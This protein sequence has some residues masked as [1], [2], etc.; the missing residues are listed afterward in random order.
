LTVLDVSGR[1]LAEAAARLGAAAE[2]VTWLEG[3]V[4]EARLPPS[5]YDV[6]HDRAVFHFLTEPDH[7]RRYVEQ[8]LSAVRLGGHVMVATFAPDGPVK[9]SGLPVARYSPD[10]L[11]EQFGR[12]FRLL[13]SA[14]E[15]HQIPAG[16]VQPFIDCLCRV[17]AG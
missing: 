13:E 7:R 16:A 1:A 2:R 10:G 5:A 11:H 12:E 15:E 14:R 3:D 4:L 8:V 9:C 6:W 17:G